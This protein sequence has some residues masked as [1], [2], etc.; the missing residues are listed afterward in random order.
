[1]GAVIGLDARV[2]EP[3]PNGL[4]TYA[5]QLIAA[6]TALESDHRFVIIRRPKSGP[7]IAEGPRVSEA[8]VAG[9]PSTPTFAFGI[10][11][12]GLDLFHSLHHFLPFGLRGPRIVVT[13]H[14]LIWLEHPRLI[15]SG[16]IAP[17]TRFVTHLYGRAAMRY[18]VRG[19][20]HVI[21]I[22]EHSRSRALAY[23]GLDPSR[24]DVIH[25]GVTHGVFTPRAE[26]PPPHDQPY[27]LCLGNTLPYKNIP[28]AVRAFA[29]CARHRPE[30]R[31]VIA[32]RGDSTAQL[33]GLTRQLGIDERTTFTGPVDQD[34]LLRLLHGAV[35]LVFPSI[36]EGFGLPVL[37]AM[38]AGCPVLASTCP[39]LKE[40]AGDAALFCDPMSSEDFAAAMERLVSDTS[41]RREL[42]GRGLER[43]ANFT[44]R[45]C[46][47][48]TLGI[49][50]S[51]LA[52]A[53][54]RQPAAG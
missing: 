13:L 3:T 25:H 52:L 33:R 4:G 18:A 50:E 40:I 12:L 39:T 29:A 35:A 11:R 28:V 26:H 54:R 2:V 16:G 49:Y 44:W 51:V 22:S 27:F 34:A 23:F 48:R 15:R 30:L 10:E 31:L 9:A 41:L 21:A 8:V 1:M 20:D 32:G 43:S 14:D 17:V 47:E 42:R 46:A 36:I 37:E 19:A 45:R 24:I 5:R 6:L 53:P 38:A 7:P